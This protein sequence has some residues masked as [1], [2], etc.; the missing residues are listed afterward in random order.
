MKLLL[1]LL[2]GLYLFYI[3]DA[4]K[5]LGVFHCTSK[6]HYNLGEAIFK[7]LHERGHELTVLTMFPQ[8]EPLPGYNEID[9]VEMRGLK[10]CKYILL[11]S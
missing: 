5:I 1:S 3:I 7:A 6:S 11:A 10:K 4:S 2:T 8:K 9:L